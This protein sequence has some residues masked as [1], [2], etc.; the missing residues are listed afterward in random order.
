MKI[1]VSGSSGLVGSALVRH[2]AGEEHRIIRLLRSQGGEKEAAIS[3][4]GMAAADLEDLDWV[5]HLAGENIAARRWS[6]AQKE[7]IRSSR[8][9][10]TQRL[11]QM[12]A[13]T[14]RPPG[15]L[16]CA[17]AMGY[18]GDRGAEVL[19]ED[20]APGNGCLPATC[21][22]WEAAAAPAL[23]RGIRVVQLRF[24]LVISARGGALERM[25][26]P[27]KMGVGGR[28]GSGRQYMSWIALDDAVGIIEHALKTEA[29]QGPVNTAVPRALTNVEFTRVLGR[30]LRRPTLLPLPAFAARLVLGEMADG[31]LLS[32]CRM[33]PERLGETG[34]EFI[35][36]DLEELLRHLLGK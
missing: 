3:W 8:V 33:V 13:Q 9:E 5:V 23:E 16:V 24:G 34:Y 30:V 36:P 21:Q 10:T 4:E 18:Y 29:L 2:F 25:I 17:S 35:H 7:R 1:L 26:L 19:R 27:F 20:S 6:A 11:C 12:L 31:L 32:S 28:I 22:Q 15:V 14:E